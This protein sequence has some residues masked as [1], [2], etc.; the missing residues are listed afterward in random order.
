ML[1]TKWGLRWCVEATFFVFVSIFIPI[2]SFAN[3]PL[4]EAKTYVRDNVAY[5]ACYIPNVRSDE[6]KKRIV[7][8]ALEKSASQIDVLR[9]KAEEQYEE[10]KSK[11]THEAT[12]QPTNQLKEM[13]DKIELIKLY[14]EIWRGL[15]HIGDAPHV[16][17]EKVL[18]EIALNALEHVIS[19]RSHQEQKAE[20]ECLTD[21][22]GIVGSKNGGINAELSKI[23]QKRD[24]DNNHSLIHSLIAHVEHLTQEVI[25]K[26]FQN[27]LETGSTQVEITR[28]SP[29]KGWPIE[30]MKLS[31]RFKNQKGDFAGMA[32]MTL[33]GGGF[34]HLC[35]E[36][37]FMKDR[38]L[39]GAGLTAKFMMAN[40]ELL[41]KFTE[42][43]NAQITL[44]AWTGYEYGMGYE[45]GGYIW[46]PYGFEYDPPVFGG[47]PK[48]LLADQ[49][50]QWLKNSYGPERNVEKLR[51]RFRHNALIHDMDDL[52][53][54]L[55]LS[56]L[57]KEELEKIEKRIRSWNHPW[58]MALFDTRS[59]LGRPLGK[60]FGK[61]GKEF[62][63]DR[64]EKVRWYGHL[65]VNKENDQGLGQ[66]FKYADEVLSR[67]RIS[68]DF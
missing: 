19:N 5:A 34:P 41:R 7:S 50:I 45:Y 21:S 24:N 8:F 52:N 11:G 49:F 54:E 32:E 38:S 15:E 46:A 23:K 36:Q 40:I 67:P 29:E 61:L 12:H 55:F 33:I 1:D 62:M 56:Q 64:E 27:L 10:L 13:T 43:P 44:K 25:D 53:P 30:S 16:D 63:S 35:I 58:E 17:Y 66:F 39:R 20:T 51:D 68:S 48:D 2:A 22:M 59:E 18:T 47:Q 6:A 4:E 60:F 26:I 37:I 14:G 42:N 3:N 28:R 9:K 31:L 57:S 65:N